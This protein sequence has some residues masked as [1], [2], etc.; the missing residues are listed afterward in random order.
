MQALQ[1]IASRC[2]VRLEFFGSSRFSVQPVLCVRHSIVFWAVVI[3]HIRV[4]V[5]A[6]FIGKKVGNIVAAAIVLWKHQVSHENTPVG[7]ASPWVNLEP[8]G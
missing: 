8:L 6:D 5:L 1:A 2:F 4:G 3:V 7:Q